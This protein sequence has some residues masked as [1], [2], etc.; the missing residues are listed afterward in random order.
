MAACYDNDI[1]EVTAPHVRCTNNR[2]K[3]AGSTRQNAISQQPC[4]IANPRESNFNYSIVNYR[5]YFIHT[6]VYMVL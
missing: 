3:H 2:H 4:E 1:I 6:G 5:K